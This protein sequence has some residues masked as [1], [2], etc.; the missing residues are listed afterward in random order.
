MSIVG[1]PAGCGGGT[2]NPNGPYGAYPAA[3]CSG[4]VIMIGAI[5]LFFGGFLRFLHF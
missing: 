2:Y 3:G 1:G 4:C 5:I